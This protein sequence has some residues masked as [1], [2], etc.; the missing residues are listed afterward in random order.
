MS[1]KIFVALFA[2]F[3]AGSA[4]AQPHR[5]TYN[6]SFPNQPGSFNHWAK[7]SFNNALHT[8]GVT[9]VVDYRTGQV[10][11]GSVNNMNRAPGVTIVEKK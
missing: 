8:N 7:T 2:L 1:T 9:R 4:Y 5:F 11:R 6:P 10:Y 3:A